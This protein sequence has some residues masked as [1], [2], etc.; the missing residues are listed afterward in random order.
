MRHDGGTADA[1]SSCDYREHDH[2]QKPKPRKTARTGT[3]MID[4]GDNENK[5]MKM[6][7]LNPK[8]PK[9]NPRRP[10]TPSCLGLSR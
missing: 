9:S 8:P 7:T 2:E 10:Q 3:A 1:E 6:T 5:P 4:D